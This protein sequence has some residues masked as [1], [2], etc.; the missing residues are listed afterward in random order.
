M[1]ET[2]GQRPSEMVGIKNEIEKLDFDAA[3]FIRAR[4]IEKEGKKETPEQELERLKMQF[5]T[6]GFGAH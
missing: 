5:S 3:V 4:T 2:Y 6:L 1:A